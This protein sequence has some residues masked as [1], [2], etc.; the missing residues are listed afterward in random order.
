MRL[1]L[2]F[3]EAERQ[4]AR[5]TIVLNFFGIM[6]VVLLLFIAAVAIHYLLGWW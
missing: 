5:T 4:R 6:L 3:T 1:R 2:F